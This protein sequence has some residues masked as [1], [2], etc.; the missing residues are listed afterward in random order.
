MEQKIE[1][2][3][4]KMR[5]KTRKRG[6][7][8]KMFKE[9]ANQR[10]EDREN[11]NKNL[12]EDVQAEDFIAEET[13]GVIEGIM[14]EKNAE[15]DQ[16]DALLMPPPGT[17]RV[18][19]AGLNLKDTIQEYL[20]HPS[21]SAPE[22]QPNTTESTE[23]E[24]D[25]LDLTGIDDAEIDGYVMTSKEVEFKT[26]MWL[27][28]NAE[29]LKEQEEKAERE[30]KEI[31]EAEKEGREIKVKKPRKKDS[32]KEQANA[33]G[34]NKTE[35]HSTAIEAIEKIVA[36]KKISTKINYDVL[37]SLNS[38]GSAAASPA[39]P[40]V[41]GSIRS[42][43]TSSASSEPN[44]NSVFTPSLNN[45]MR[46]L[47]SFKRREDRDLSLKRPAAS[48]MSPSSKRFGGNSTPKRTRLS[49]SSSDVASPAPSPAPASPAPPSP[50]VPA[51]PAPVIIENG[52]V[53]VEPASEAEDFE[54]EDEPTEILSARELLSRH[55]GE[56]YGEDEF[57]EDYY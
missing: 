43:S 33:K 22:P 53:S 27:K 30:R 56:Q 6:P 48:P 39:S 49:S 17:Q 40:S 23:D 57:E 54:D 24:S 41:F 7:Y 51:S 42:P 5:A 15:R 2:E 36:E 19:V 37:R 3:L 12:P 9:A 20:T 50:A 46:R 44:P 55:T 11:A 38:S 10:K 25:E 16:L 34:K 13:L 1:D 29:Y 52:P 21:E 45:S 4:D 32:A 26:K 8:A 14:N 47:S 35:G 18:P 31:E 28:A